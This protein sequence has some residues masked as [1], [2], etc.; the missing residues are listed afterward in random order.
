MKK[1]EVIQKHQQFRKVD[2]EVK[3]ELG[4]SIPNVEGIAKMFGTRAEK[5]AREI[6][7]DRG[8]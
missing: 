2:F 3:M 1:D 7:K 8:E 6:L 4:M 5:A